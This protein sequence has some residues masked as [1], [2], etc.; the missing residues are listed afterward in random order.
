MASLLDTIDK[1][2]QMV[3]E[4]RL[5]LLLFQLDAPQRYGINVFKVKE[6]LQCP[7]LTL[8]PGRNP[9]VK[10]IAS[11]RGGTLPIID[12]QM[13]MGLAP[14]EGLERRFIVITEYNRMIQGF[15]V[16]SVE[17]IINTNWEDM[18]P[19]PQGSGADS[20]LTAVTEFDKKMVEVLDVE[21]ILAEVS[22]R[23]V[24]VSDGLIQHD[25][26]KE[27]EVEHLKILIVDDSSVA[28]NQMKRCISQLG[29]EMV[30]KND[31]AQALN[32][33]KEIADSGEDVC[34]IFPVIVSDIEM[35]EMDG[36]TL[37]SEIRA[38]PRLEKLF[39]MLHTSL[40]GVFNEAMIKKVGAND[41]LAKFN[42]DDLVTKVAARIE[43]VTGSSLLGKLNDK[44]SSE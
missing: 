36:Y 23:E 31:G 5:E 16:S 14:Q 8:M 27:L 38:D 20:Y 24:D 34:Q 2:T 3:G 28:R 43:D 30:I 12:L 25:A 33:L 26:V 1:R 21:K 9:V 18:H 35:P 4:N 13:A 10:G 11:I 40:S 22:P 19:P 7:P 29:F 42:P 41:F 44:E 37:T 6:V 39:I 17:R 32:Y 15:L